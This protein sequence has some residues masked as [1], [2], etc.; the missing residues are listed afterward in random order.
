MVATAVT[1]EVLV[2]RLKLYLCKVE[3][4]RGHHIVVGGRLLS[5]TIDGVTTPHRDMPVY[6]MGMFPVRWDAWADGAHPDVRVIT[7]ASAAGKPKLASCVRACSLLFNPRG[8]ETVKSWLRQ[9][10]EVHH[11]HTGVDGS[12]TRPPVAAGR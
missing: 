4:P 7:Q 6:E 9:Q 11:E 10:Q 12:P 8:E 2:E 3:F 1:V 5:T